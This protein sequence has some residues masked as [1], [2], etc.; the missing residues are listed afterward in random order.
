MYIHCGNHSLD[1]ALHD[2]VKES[3]IISDT[4][5]AIAVSNTV[6]GKNQSHLGCLAQLRGPV[7][8]IT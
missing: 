3:E 6:D 7:L 8:H 5:K 1:P 4:L 2:C